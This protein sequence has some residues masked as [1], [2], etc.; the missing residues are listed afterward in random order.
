MQRVLGPDGVCVH[1]HAPQVGRYRHMCPAQG[2]RTKITC[3][4]SRTDYSVQRYTR[5]HA[6][7]CALRAAQMRALVGVRIS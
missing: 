6:V 4:Y 2:V 3:T 5:Q 7:E 1:V